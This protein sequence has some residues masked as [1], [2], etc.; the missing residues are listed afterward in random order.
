MDCKITKKMI[1]AY[2]E[3]QNISHNNETN[4]E[5]EYIKNS[6]KENL[7]NNIKEEIVILE[8]DRIIEEA[9]EEIIKLEQERKIKEIKVLMYEGFFIAFVVGLIVNQMT[10]ILNISKGVDTKVTITLLWIV[11][12]GIATISLYKNKFLSDVANTIREKLN[13]KKTK[14]E[15]K[16]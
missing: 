14:E 11:V 16:K 3:S 5:I 7:F 9:K 8:K 1:N 12:L 13:N 6:A 4:E 15:G 10:E 2:V